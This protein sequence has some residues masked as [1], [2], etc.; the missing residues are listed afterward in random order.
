M[1]LI[2]ST[3]KT[4]RIPV[5]FIDGK[6]INQI[7]GEEVGG[8]E[9]NA[10]CEIVVEANKVFDYDLLD[11]LTAEETIELLPSETVLY[12]SISPKH[13]PESLRKYAIAQSDKEKQVKI[14]LISPLFLKMRG[15]KPPML[16]DCVCDIPSLRE[17]AKDF[18]PAESLNHAYRLISTAF[19]PHRRSFGGSVFLNITIPPQEGY[20][21]GTSLS[22]LRRIKIDE[23]YEQLKEKYQ[24]LKNQKPKQ[25]NLFG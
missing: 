15:T 9:N 1:L 25:T 21:K 22:H 10:D 23:H 7:T 11:L 24:E 12:A 6:F 13:I 20:Q 16:L 18:E 14:E 4:A 2:D 17:T 8:I 5:K 3:E 19:E